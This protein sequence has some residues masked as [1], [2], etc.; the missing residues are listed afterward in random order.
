[1]LLVLG[2]L[3]LTE[4]KEKNKPSEWLYRTNVK[5]H[6]IWFPALHSGWKPM[7]GD[8]VEAGDIEWPFLGQLSAGNG[9]A[10]FK[11]KLQSEFYCA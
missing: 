4:Q 2:F 8:S 7:P 6:L 10:P 1:M 11:Q 9:Q 5:V 3:H